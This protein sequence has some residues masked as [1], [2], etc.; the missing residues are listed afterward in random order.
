M[1]YTID[2]KALLERFLRLVQVDSETGKELEIAQLLE[3]ELQDLGLTVTRDVPPEIVD[4]NGFNIYAVLQGDESLESIVFSSHMDTVTPGIGVKPQVCDDGY[5]R[6][7]GTTVLGGDDKAGLCAMIEAVI[8]AKK[9]PRYPTIE[10]V[11][12][13]REESGLLGSK[14]FDYSLVKSK[15][16]IVLDSS[17]S[18][19]NITTS[20][21]GQNKINIHF[22][23]KRAH[24]GIAPEAGISAIEVGCHA[25]SK[26]R[27]L[28]IDEETTSNIGTFHSEGPTNIVSP[29]AK[30]VLEVRSL[31]YDKLMA[32]TKEISD[33]AQKTAEEFGATC[34]INSVTSYQGFHLEDSHPLVQQVIKAS[35]KIGLNP[36]TMGSGGG[37]DANEFNRQGIAM[38]NLGIGME[39]VHT[40]AEQQNIAHMCQGA[41]ICYQVILLS[42]TE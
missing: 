20:A 10:L 41:E 21:P 40:T 13:V 4:S 32:H 5:V 26:M 7:D 36:V 15:R 2:E 12:T 11:I 18:P 8:Q 27:L 19:E 31:K 33:I 25:V 38:V 30:L 23:G 16:G 39:K 35:K 42:V 37:S 24:A 3:K 6:S 34:N 28:R 14:H 22:L 9:L 17:G 29:E 1:K